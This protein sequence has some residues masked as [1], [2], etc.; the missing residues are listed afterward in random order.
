M[1]QRSAKMSK[2]VGD[3]S[4]SPMLLTQFIKECKNQLESVGYEDC[5][6][7]FE[8]IEEALRNGKSLTADPKK[9]SSILGL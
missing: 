3:G 7:Y 4:I 5:A 6:F 8:Q 9:V 1:Y 2:P